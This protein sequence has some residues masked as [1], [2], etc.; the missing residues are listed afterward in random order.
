MITRLGLGGP[1]KSYGTFADKGMEPIA[2]QR[3]TGLGIGGP[4]KWGGIF[5]AKAESGDVGADG[6]EFI[7]TARRRGRR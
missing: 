6:F 3:I 2:A 7:I 4:W 5:A 1:S